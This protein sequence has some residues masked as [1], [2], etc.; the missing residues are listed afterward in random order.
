MKSLLKFLSVFIILAGMA[1]WAQDQTT[2]PPADQPADQPQANNQQPPQDQNKKPVPPKSSGEKPFNFGLG[3]A[4]ESINGVPYLSIA[5]QP[6]LSLG[7]FGIGLDVTFR[8]DQNFNLYPP[9]WDP[10]QIGRVILSKINYIRWDKKGAP[11]FAKIGLLDNVYLGHGT[12]FYRYSNKLFLPD[13]RRTG[14]QF[15]LDLKSFG[16]EL[17]DDDILDNRIFGGRLYVRPFNKSGIFFLNKLAVGLSGAADIKLDKLTSNPWEVYLAGVDLDLPV[18]KLGEIFSLLLYCDWVKNFNFVKGSGLTPG[19]FLTLFGFEFRGEY[20]MYEANFDGV[21]F[22]PFYDM[23]RNIKLAALANISKPAEGWSIKMAKQFAKILGVGFDIGANRG[24]NPD[25]HFE[26]GIKEK[27][28]NKVR[29]AIAYDHKD[30]NTFG[31]AFNF[32]SV[33]SI[34]SASIEYYPADTV[35]IQLM[36]KKTFQLNPD[37]VTYSSHLDTSVE[38][39]LTF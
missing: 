3:I 25:M 35:M 27:I 10:K 17:F 9:D 14:L 37:G 24:E 7:K 6:D 5:L 22:G 16:W 31:D 13:A 2:P 29:G 12:L 4:S 15:D 23:E 34:L 8:F 32:A 38:T 21:Y 18:F 11:F 1:V 36:L 20:H 33:N 28:A 30:I 19:A 26:I 39:Q